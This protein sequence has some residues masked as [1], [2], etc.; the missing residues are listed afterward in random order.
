[1][2]NARGITIDATD[3]DRI[4][5]TTDTQLLD[6]WLQRAATATTDHDLFD[7]TRPG[8]RTER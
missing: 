5:T 3:R 1:M 2:L 7:R 4:L 8:T 6:T